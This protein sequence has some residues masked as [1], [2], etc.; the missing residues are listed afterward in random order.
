LSLESLKMA[1]AEWLED[2]SDVVGKKPYDIVGFSTTFEQTNGLAVLA[3]HCRSQFPNMTLIAGGANC[4][5]SM[6]PAIKKLVPEIDYVFSGESEVAFTKFLDT[7]G[8]YSGRTI[9]AS[10]PNPNLNEIPRLDFSEFFEQLDY[11]LP[12]S[13]LR[14]ANELR[15][16]YETSRGCWWGQKHHCTFC[17]LNGNGMGY[18]EKSPERVVD[19]VAA[20]S[21]ETGVKRIGMVD[22]IMPHSYFSTVLPALTE[23][24]LSL[25]IFWE[26]KAN[27]SL[28]KVIALKNAGVNH[29]Q[30]GIESLQDDLLRLMKK[31][32]S[33]KQNI[34]LLRYARA[35][36]MSV[37]WNMLTGFPGDREEWYAET[38]KLVPL[39][40]HLEPPSGMYKLN[41][42]RFSPY[43]ERA[44]EF[45]IS[46]MR[47]A[48]SYA[49]AF[50]HCD[51]LDELAYHF[52]GDT[53]GH[54]IDNSETL[55]QLDTAIDTWRKH[56]DKTKDGHNL[57]C[58][59]VVE[60]DPD[61]YLLIDSRPLPNSIFMQ[62]ITAQ[63]A[64]VALSFHNEDSALTR[65]GTERSV[66]VKGPNGY[67]PLACAAPGVLERFERVLAPDLADAA[68]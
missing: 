2:V 11:W 61:N 51:F 4:E 37:E 34:A 55:R 26:Q 19:E 38:L 3:K 40:A 47:P 68:V 10:P 43:F 50:P 58:L 63:Q 18:R 62:Q 46:G 31:G 60:V 67:I 44:A 29:I 48:A 13:N 21:A 65:W 36:G 20:L 57:P 5:G 30:P 28:E 9:I 16:P 6:A 17:G 66:C 45:G 39:L 25:D 53:R 15:L 22:N 42:D 12:E 32:T 35:I 27:M 41:F 64:S 23:A 52:T 59:E 7:P 14:S 49:E 56:W 54:T 24:N 8:D 1:M 33:G